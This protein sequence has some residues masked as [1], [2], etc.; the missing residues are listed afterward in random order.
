[1]SL[2]INL[3]L[4]EGDLA[5]FRNKFREARA[6]RGEIEQEQLIQRS[7]ELI[8]RG[9]DSDPPEFVR[10]R[11]VSMSRVVTM[12]ED[13]A[14][15]LPSDEGGP[16]IDALAY[17]LHP[18]DTIPDDVPVL[19]LIDDA[20]AIDLVLGGLRH[21]LE[22]YEEFS[23]YRAAETQRRSN[24]GQPT[25]ISKEDWLADRRAALHSRMRERRAQDASGWNY[26]SL[27]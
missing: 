5:Y 3:R 21:E 27:G 6:K 11:L 23:A 25:D 16:I 14:W 1:M 2:E 26:T 10:K 20:I 17:L 19:G 4:E 18:E 24:L 9:L 13:E 22:A 15:R 7:Y 8:E 12:L